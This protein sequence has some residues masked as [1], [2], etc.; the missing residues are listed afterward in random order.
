[1][2]QQTPQDKRQLAVLSAR[3]KELDERELNIVSHEKKLPELEVKIRVLNLRRGQAE[4]KLNTITDKISHL[5]RLEAEK[6]SF[7]AE[8][9]IKLSEQ[10][11]MAQNGKYKLDEELKELRNSKK[12]LIEEIDE[13]KYYL[14]DQEAIITETIERGNQEFANIDYEIKE[15]YKRKDMEL[16]QLKELEQAKKKLEHDIIEL[17]ER[18]Q[19]LQ[20]LYTSNLARFK[21]SLDDI[22][23][24]IGEARAIY[25]ETTEKSKILIEKLSA[26]EKELKEKDLILNEREGRIADTERTLESKRRLYASV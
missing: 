3:T 21:Q 14:A 20:E 10:A 18:Y 9:D 13:R 6:L 4:K 19:K 15:I 24:K 1:M 2:S 16:I 11:Q 25:Q 8:Y 26:K 12:T 5:E 17:D 22:K 7:I 23:D